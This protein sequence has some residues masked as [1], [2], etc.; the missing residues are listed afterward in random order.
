M[1]QYLVGM[2][3]SVSASARSR[4]PLV[5]ALLGMWLASMALQVLADPAR[6]DRNDGAHRPE[7]RMDQRPFDADYNP[8][9]VFS[10]GEPASRRETK[11]E[12]RFG[13]VPLAP[14]SAAVPGDGKL[15]DEEKRILRQSIQDAGRDVYRPKF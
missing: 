3:G 14:A 8:G 12:P 6:Q 7:S 5:N 15:T 9:R 10:P 13:V 1:A 2:T 4:W 11:S